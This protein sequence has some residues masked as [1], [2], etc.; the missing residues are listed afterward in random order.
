M[1]ERLR[2]E[3]GVEPVLVDA[4]GARRRVGRTESA[5]GAKTRR[6]VRQR[7][8]HCRF[9]GCDR[10][11][12]LEVHHL[13]PVSWGGTDA[14]ANLATVCSTHHA[15]LAPQGRLP[16]AREPEPPGGAH[17]ARPRRPPGP[18]GG[19]RTGPSRSRRPLRRRPAR[20]QSGGVGRGQVQSG[21]VRCGGRTGS[22]GWL[23]RWTPA[24]GRSATVRR[25]PGSRRGS[26]PSGRGPRR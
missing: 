21:V 12:G 8:G 9:P 26:G 25:P 10:R 6:V 14:I 13:W 11:V 3:A 19:H 5:L 4:E 24:A 7:D 16:P 22:R 23:R 15:R 18:R 17:P 2:A 1:V 20:A